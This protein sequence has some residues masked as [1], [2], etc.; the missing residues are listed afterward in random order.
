MGADDE[1]VAVLLLSFGTA[2]AAP[3]T[4]EIGRPV[5]ES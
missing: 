5:T 2:A 4:F 3:P 1:L